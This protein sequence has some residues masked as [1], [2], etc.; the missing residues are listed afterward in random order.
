MNQS[1]IHYL[2]LQVAERPFRFEE[3][4]FE[5]LDHV[6]CKFECS[7]LDDVKV[8]WEKEKVNWTWWKIIKLRI[9]FHNLMIWEF[10]KCY[11]KSMF[12]IQIQDLK[13]N[14][15]FLVIALLLG[16]NFYHNE[17]IM[18]GIIVCLW[19]V[20]PVSF[21]SWIYHN[22]ETLGEKLKIFKNKRVVSAKSDAMQSVLMA[23]FF[24]WYF[25]LTKGGEYLGIEEYF[26]FA[27]YH[28]SISISIIFLMLVSTRSFYQL[29]QSKLKPFLY[30]IK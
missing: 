20:F 23:N 28:P 19:F 10:Y 6:L 24:I 1:D 30:E 21:Q 8:F 5:I 29:Y 26:G 2:E 17:S 7:E 13:V 15:T 11:L 27:F 22:R 16:L 4:Y 18:T 9:K 12:S 14:F 3:L 25:A